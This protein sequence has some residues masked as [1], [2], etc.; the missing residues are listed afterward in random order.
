LGESTTR[1]R[2]LYQDLYPPGSFD[3][4][5]QAAQRFVLLGDPAVA[6]DAGTPEIR[7]T[8]N[9]V[10]AANGEYLDVPAQT[11]GSVEIAATVRHGRGITGIRVLDTVRGEVP[12]AELS[13]AVVDS[14]ADGV[15]RAMSLSYS[16]PLRA[17]TYDLV[18]EATNERGAVGR[19]TLRVSS[20]LS[21][22]DVS[23]FPNPFENELRLYYRLTRRADEVRARIFT[24]SG[25]KIYETE[26]APV[27]ADVNVFTWDGKDDAGNLVANGTYLLTL[28]ASGSDGDSEAITRVVKMR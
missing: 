3:R 25:R 5:R 4:D 8:V 28:H 17:D 23:P 2:L 19:F 24:V 22:L 16:H 7:V 15:A 18:L 9:G 6:P 20:E 26:G 10:P 1:A 27:E 21:I 13:V 14:S 11:P 12:P